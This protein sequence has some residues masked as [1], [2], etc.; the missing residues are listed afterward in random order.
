MS[1][2]ST[3]VTPSE[4]TLVCARLEEEYGVRAAPGTKVE[5][6]FCN[7]QT[8][9]IRKDDTV[10]KCFH[11]SCGRYLTP[12]SANAG[13]GPDLGD[14]IDAV[15]EALRRELRRLSSD[16]QSGVNAYKYCLS[17]G[18]HPR[19]L[20]DSMLGAVPAKPTAVV[21]EAFKP[22]Q[23]SADARLAASKEKQKQKG[24]P[25]KRWLLRRRR[26]VL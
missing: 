20:E 16:S 15:G 23:E 3:R 5:C 1:S 13:A 14:A 21:E 17:R 12:G 24:R 6:P 8:F 4:R 18:L 7:H 25:P 19:V 26:S 22:A 11:A 10:G 9:A 2:A